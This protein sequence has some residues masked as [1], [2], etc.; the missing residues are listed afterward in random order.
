MRGRDWFAAFKTRHHLSCRTPEAT[1]LGG[2][3]AFNR[4]NVGEFFDNLSTVMDRYKFSPHKIY[5]MDETGVTTVQT[6]KQIVTEKG[7]KQVGSVTSTER[8]ELV[9]VACAVNATGNAI[10]PMF[11]FPRVC[12]KEQ[13]LNGSPA[14]SVGH[15]TRSGW[16]NE[17]AFIIFMN[18]FIRQTN[19]STNHPV[20]LILD[21]HES[22]ISLKAVTTAK[23]NGVVMLTL[24]PHT[25]H[26]LQPLEKTVYYSI[27]TYYNRAVDGWMRTNPGRT[28]TIYQIPGLVNQAFMSAMTPRNITSGFRVTGIFPFNRDIFPDEDYA[29]SMLTDRSNP[30]KP[31]TSTPADL[32]GLSHEE[33]TT[34]LEAGPDP[35]E[36]PTSPEPNSEQ[37]SI[38]KTGSSVHLGYISPEP[39]LPL[40]KASTRRPRM[41]KNIKS[42]IVTEEE[43]DDE[44]AEREKKNERQV[45]RALKQ[46]NQTKFKKMKKT[47][48]YRRSEESTMAIPLNDNTDDDE[49]EDDM[50]NTHSRENE[51]GENK[52]RRTLKGSKPTK[53]KTKAA[54]FSS[55]EDSDISIPL[56]DTTDYESSDVQND[57][58]DDDIDKDLS[59]G[60]FAIVNFAGK[61][62]SDNYIELVE[63]ADGVDISAKFLRQSNK[64]SVDGKNL[65]TFKESDE[66][67]IPREDGPTDVTGEDFHPEKQAPFHIKQEPEMPDIKQAEPETFRIKEEE[68]EDEITNFPMNVSVKSEEDD[69]ENGAAKPSSD[70]SFHYLTTKGEGQSQPDGLLAPLSDS[71]DITSHSSDFNT[72]EEDDD[73][74]RNASKSLNK[75]SLTRDAKECAGGKPFACS[76]CDKRYS[77]KGYL[78]IHTKTHTKGN[79]FACSFCEKIFCWKYLLTRHTR[80]H[81]G[82]RPFACSLCGQRFTQKGHLV[83]HTKKTLE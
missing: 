3:S 52:K 49:T 53:P 68:Q 66:G 7:K 16:M 78:D 5:S 46:S 31:S 36:S 28:V 62:K 74:G 26:R 22:H 48:V 21:N 11:V 80:M 79:S 14:G 24:P 27:K 38:D 9:T 30:E 55:S 44:M 13:F 81:T 20:L 12:F 25:S 77:K 4:H 8:G 73:F 70:S 59:A 63:K 57:D 45:K 6:P 23:E 34:G 2:A 1:S 50:Q 56:H 18:H 37:S 65:S 76:V 42:K 75:S 83:L 69:I 29:P 64:R 54:V 35:G 58:N 61:T 17:E 41:K 51:R 82:E 43:K 40:P 19:C 39:I 10:P 67:V 32:P 15:S 71:D 33:P 60:D 47:V 72:D